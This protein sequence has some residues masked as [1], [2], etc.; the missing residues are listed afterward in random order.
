MRVEEW[1]KERG[2]SGGCR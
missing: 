1:E 2:R